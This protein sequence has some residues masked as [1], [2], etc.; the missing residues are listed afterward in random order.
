MGSNEIRE[1]L[2]RHIRASNQEAKKPPSYE[3]KFTNV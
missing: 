3:K 2:D 1:N